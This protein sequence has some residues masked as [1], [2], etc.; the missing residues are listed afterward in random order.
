[1]RDRLGS[2][3]PD[4]EAPARFAL[5]RR[6]VE[7]FGRAARPPLVPEPAQLWASSRSIERFVC[8]SREASRI[9]LAEA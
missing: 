8:Q 7:R 5:D 2:V 6:H 3:P 1:V 9:S 4:R